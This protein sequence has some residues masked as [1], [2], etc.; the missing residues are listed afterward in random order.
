ML[1]WKCSSLAQRGSSAGRPDQMP[2]ASPAWKAAP[3]AV[4]SR[5]V[6]RST[7]RS[8]M[9]A[10]NPRSQS[11]AA[12]P[13]STRTMAS[14]TP[15]STARALRD[16]WGMQRRWRFGRAIGWRPHARGSRSS[17]GGGMGAN[18]RRHSLS[19]Q[20]AWPSPAARGGRPDRSA[21]SRRIRLVSAITPS[22][23]VVI[24]AARNRAA[25]SL[26]ESD[27]GTLDRQQG[28][29]LYGPDHPR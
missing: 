27:H 7:G 24:C 18:G 19:T 3:R 2:V 8:R 10:R 15:V 25:P 29:G 20:Q 5:S 11:F 13:P 26:T 21:P 22:R 23:S 16:C 9:S 28:P 12:M 17:G 4:A 14:R 1:G 6:G